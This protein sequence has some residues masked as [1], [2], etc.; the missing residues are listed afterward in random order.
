MGVE[1]RSPPN[2]AASWSRSET[3]HP[4]SPGS[5]PCAPSPPV[6]HFSSPNRGL[7]S[8]CRVDLSGQESKLLC[9]V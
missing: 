6:A 9:C 5:R 8:T 4:P 7:P 3:R 1:V 2:K